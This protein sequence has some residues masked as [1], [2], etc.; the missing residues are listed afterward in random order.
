MQQEKEFFA[1]VLRLAQPHTS[2]DRE[3]STVERETAIAALSEAQVQQ[4][5]DCGTCLTFDLLYL[6]EPIN[7]DLPRTYLAASSKDGDALVLAHLVGD[8]LA[9][10]EVAPTGGKLMQVL[11]ATDQLTP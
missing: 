10:L 5:C 3:L 1:A 8:K 4:T 9:T 7:Q 6:G 2:E 11:P